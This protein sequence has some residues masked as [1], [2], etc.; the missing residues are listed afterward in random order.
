MIEMP[1]NIAHHAK[2][3]EHFLYLCKTKLSLYFPKTSQ[4]TPVALEVNRKTGKSGLQGG[5][6]SAQP[7][8]LQ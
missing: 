5:V 8:E 4:H 6:N 7:T 3:M 1:Q 2:P